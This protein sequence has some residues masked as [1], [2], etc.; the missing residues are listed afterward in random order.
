[1]ETEGCIAERS[2][3]IRIK[4]STQAS[5]DLGQKTKPTRFNR[6]TELEGVKHKIQFLSQ[7]FR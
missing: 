4:A 7:L 1:M 2:E 5:L 6:I 3:T